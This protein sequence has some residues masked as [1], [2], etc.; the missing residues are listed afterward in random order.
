MSEDLWVPT[1]TT[2]RKVLPSERKDEGG[3]FFDDELD[4]QASHDEKFLKDMTELMRH[5]NERPDH[6]IYVGSDDDRHKL[7]TVFNAWKRMSLIG[8]NPNIRIDYGVP[9]G[10]I[11][12]DE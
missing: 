10:T 8:H 9:D 6:T 12:V 3:T 4:T 5:I 7:R 1:Q 2:A 11:R